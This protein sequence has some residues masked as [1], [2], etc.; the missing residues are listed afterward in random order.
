M[1]AITHHFTPKEAALAAVGAGV[2]IVLVCHEPDQQIQAWEALLAGYQDDEQIRSSIERASRR[3]I[4]FKNKWQ[5]W[6][7]W[8]K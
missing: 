3:I 8:Q 7:K 6:Q 5:K 4:E 1:K 2:D